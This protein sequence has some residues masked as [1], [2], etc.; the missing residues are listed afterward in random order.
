MTD[1]ALVVTEFYGAIE[2]GRHGGD[3]DQF[4]A[5]DARALERPNA[6]APQGRTSD[7]ASMIAASSAG[8]GLLS[9]QRYEVHWLREIEDTVVTRVTW[10]GVVAQDAGPFR[11]GQELTAHI[12]QFIQVRDGRIVEIDT[13]DC[14]EPF[15]DR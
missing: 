2:H 10:R 15:N 6:L 3:L 5:H 13:Y 9:R 4:F 7:R 1:A 8:A 11:A 12:A 14:Y